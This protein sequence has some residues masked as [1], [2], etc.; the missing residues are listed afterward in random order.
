[1]SGVIDGGY[2]I[3]DGKQTWTTRKEKKVIA[4]RGMHDRSGDA[5]M[6]VYIR[7]T[8]PVNLLLRICYHF[9][10]KPN[11]THISNVRPLAFYSEILLMTHV[12]NILPQEIWHR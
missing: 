4:G 8:V 11:L 12:I 7:T 6:A 1:M 2:C 10:R 3:V 9:Q 5:N